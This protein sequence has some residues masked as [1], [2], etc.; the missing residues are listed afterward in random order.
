[1]MIKT[2]LPLGGVCYRAE[3][4]RSGH[5]IEYKLYLNK[6]K[7]RCSLFSSSQKNNPLL[8]HPFL[9]HCMASFEKDLKQWFSNFLMP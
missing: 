3:Y 5:F 9:F 7:S 2:L 6:N 4:L 1:M 8:I